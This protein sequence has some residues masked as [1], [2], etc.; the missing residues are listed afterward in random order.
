MRI[1]SSFPMV[2]TGADATATATVEQQFLMA[3]NADLFG[4]CVAYYNQ[5]KKDVDGLRSQ[6]DT[7]ANLRR[8][9]DEL[10]S[11]D[12]P[13]S[14]RAR[15]VFE[16]IRI[17]TFMGNGMVD[18]LKQNI[19]AFKDGCRDLMPDQVAEIEALEDEV[20]A[21]GRSFQFAGTQVEENLRVLSAEGGAAARRT[22]QSMSVTLG[23][24]LEN[25]GTALA[26]LAAFVIGVLEFFRRLNP[27]LI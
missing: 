26:P 18:R 10:L 4:Q 22:L 21:I 8:T 23:S 14:Q 7:L 15:Q 17:V 24:V 2:G 9:I 3:S 12:S 19:Q 1:G 11:G 5:I 16:Q 27:G 6:R 20:D 25:L 13:D